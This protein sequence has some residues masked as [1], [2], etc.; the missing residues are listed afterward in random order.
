[1][2][3]TVEPFE[4]WYREG[5]PMFRANWALVNDACADLPLEPQWDRWIAL[6]R[7]GGAQCVTARIG[8][9]LAGYA[10]HCIG[11][12]LIYG[13]ALVASA[14]ALY[15]E[16]AELAGAKALR[17]SRLIAFADREL[18]RRGVVKTWHGERTG[19]ALGPFLRRNGYRAE[20]RHWGRMLTVGTPLR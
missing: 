8:W 6:D 11:P 17:L 1:M 12:S 15:I 16:P 10:I 7:A 13:G 20:E 19:H 2:R 9:R 5:E 4:C 18:E 3:F 14:H